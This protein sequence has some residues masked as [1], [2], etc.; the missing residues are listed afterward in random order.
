[1]M[2]RPFSTPAAGALAAALAL[3]LLLPA[4]ARAERFSH[5][6]HQEQGAGEC[7]QCHLPGAVSIIPPVSVCLSC[8]KA[9][10][11]ED[12]PLGPTK[13]HTAFW[14]RQHGGES[15]APGAQCRSC[16]A[17]SFCVNCHAGGEIGVDLRRQAGKT[18]ISPRAH[19]AGFRVLHP[20]KAEGNGKKA[21]LQCHKQDFCADCH[22][23]SVP[24]AKSAS[25]SHRKSWLQIE[26]G[27]GGPVHRAFV[28]EQCPSCHPGGLL[29]TREWGAGHAQ[30][31]RQNLSSCR[32]CHPQG[33]VCSPCHSAK[34]GLKVSPH[35]ANWR[36]IQK[37]F[38]TESP[39]VCEKCHAAG[40]W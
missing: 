10:E 9:K 15:A 31:A 40:T 39:Q 33:E 17:S 13:T 16:H 22:E 27:M 11:L 18:S 29:S 8:H 35:P 12:T 28:P 3:G 34:S 36:R 5:P 6:F 32:G 2:K 24:P 26:A 7:R 20:L 23:R 19:S 30:E 14:T 37:K 38:R 4:A 21:C 25:S 1:M